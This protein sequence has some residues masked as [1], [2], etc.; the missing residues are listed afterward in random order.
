MT[1]R[2]PIDSHHACAECNRPTRCAQE[3]ACQRDAIKAAKDCLAF[4]VALAR[5]EAPTT[6][7]YRKGPWE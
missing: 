7:L 2:H 3:G 6:P 5:A 1:I 4:E